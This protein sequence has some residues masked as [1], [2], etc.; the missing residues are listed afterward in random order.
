MHP[1]LR[2][3]FEQ[4]ETDRKKLLNELIALNEDILWKAPQGK[5]S[6][7]QILTHIMVSEKLSVLYMRKK[8]HGVDQL[9]NSGA[10]ESFKVLVLKASQ[11]LPIKYSAPKVLIENTPDALPLQELIRQWDSVRDVLRNLLEKIAEKNIR[12]KIYKHPVVGRLDVLQAMAFFHE[13]IHHHWPQVKHL[14]KN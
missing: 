13:H 6:I 4:I 1:K 10:L 11:R 5:W 12:K 9:D 7:N 8:S 14:L 2:I 3:R